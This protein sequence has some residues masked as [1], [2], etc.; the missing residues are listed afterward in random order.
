MSNCGC[1]PDVVTTLK[2][3]VEST[4]P[5]PAARR[6]GRGREDED[7]RTEKRGRR[8]APGERKVYTS[9]PE[10]AP[11]AAKAPKAEKAK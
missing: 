6:A 2:V 4:T 9:K 8:P 3:R 10:K 1:M 11:E 7:V 5:P